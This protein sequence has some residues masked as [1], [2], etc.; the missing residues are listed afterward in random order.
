MALTDSVTARISNQLLVELTNQGDP[1]A[2]TVDTT[3]LALVAAD[4]EGVFLLETGIDYDDSDATHV[5]VGVDGVLFQLHA[6]TGL[7]GRNTSDLR[8]RW[9]R[10][11][12]RIAYARGSDQRLL[13]SSTS[14]L[15]PSDEVQGTRPDFDR[16]RWSGYVPHA[17]GDVDERESF[18]RGL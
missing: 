2:I 16:Q 10:G 15:D 11:L 8:E 13:P 6:Y 14:V 3:K 18:G 12:Q 7:T 9:E 5:P 4:V 17:P 1:T